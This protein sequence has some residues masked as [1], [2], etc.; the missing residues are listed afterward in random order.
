M[1]PVEKRPVEEVEED[2]KRQKVEDE[3]E[4]EEEC[5][6]DELSEDGDF[7]DEFQNGYTKEDFKDMPDITDEQ[8]DKFTEAWNEYLTKLGEACS[9]E[10]EPMVLTKPETLRPLPQSAADFEGK[11]KTMLLTSKTLDYKEELANKLAEVEEETQDFDEAEDAEISEEKLDAMFVAGVKK[12]IELF[13]GEMKSVSKLMDD[14]EWKVA[15]QKLFSLT[16]LY[17]SDDAHNLFCGK[18]V[19]AVQKSMN[20]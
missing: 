1:A 19:E 13:D 18:E 20:S 10:S 4:E 11:V 7:G 16:E 3:V 8:V 17:F 14:S 12:F 2:N 9:E 5:D 15:F 6:E